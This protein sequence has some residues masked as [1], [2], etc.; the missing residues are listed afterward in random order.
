VNKL[1][2][3]I[4]LFAFTHTSSFAQVDKPQKLKV[5]QLQNEK[6]KYASKDF[7]ISEVK[8]DREDTTNIG[9]VKTGFSDKKATL[10]LKD[11]AA[12]SVMSFLTANMKQDRLAAPIGMHIMKLDIA[13][14]RV[15]GM[16]RADIDM[17]FAFYVQGDKVIELSSSSY[18]KSGLDATMYIEET[19]RKQIASAAEQFGD[20]FAENKSELMAQP[21]VTVEVALDEHP[22]AGSEYIP[23]SIQRPLTYED[24]KG[25]PDR[26]SI[27]AAATASSV[28]F[29]GKTLTKGKQVTLTIKVGALFNTQRSWFKPDA[30]NPKVLAHEQLHFDITAYKACEFIHIIR[31]YKFTVDGYTDELQALKR[32]SEQETEQLQD[33]YDEESDHGL[34]QAKQNEWRKKVAELMAQQDCFK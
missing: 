29:D 33:Q 23:Y 8:D 24:F 7:Y 13:E 31:E 10:Q 15:G 25:R 2:A 14:K 34:I 18:V 1:I 20:W 26:L 19:I 4:A 6:I 30:K 5:I 21:S 17:K 12:A 9:F 28:S 32:K 27:G 22:S 3:L 16:D 11:G